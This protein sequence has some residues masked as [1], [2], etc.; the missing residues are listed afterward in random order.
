[1]LDVFADGE[2]A[3]RASDGTHIFYRTIGDGPATLLFLHGWGGSGS[4]AFWN[5]MKRHLDSDGRRMV[6][7]DLRGHARSDHTRDGFTTERVAQDVFEVADYL[8]ASEIVLV[9]FSM[10][11]RW[12][13]WMACTEPARIIGQLLIAPAPAIPLPLTEEMLDGWIRTT[14]TRA[15]FEGFVRQF[16]KNELASDL[17]DDYFASIQSSPEH[18]LRESFRMCCHAAF[19]DR[20]T[21]IRAATLVVGGQHDPI[22]PPDYLRQEIVRRI[23]KARLALLDCGHEIPLEQPHEMAAIIEGFLAGLGV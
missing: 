6:L 16:T 19:A 2:H 23:P 20:L 1:M 8:G 11:G 7:V 13:Q 18:S 21:A 5:P 10:S 3:I 12:A 9:A 14:R 4:G 22:L 15:T 17:V